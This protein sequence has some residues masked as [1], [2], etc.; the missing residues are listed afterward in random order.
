[1]ALT[2]YRKKRDF[3]KTPEPGGKQ[4]RRG[5][6]SGLQFV[7]Q[8]HAA[9][10]LHYDFRLELDGV[11]KSWAV[12]KGPS[13]DPSVK[14]LA[15]QVEDHPLEYGGFEGVIPEGQYGG[16]TVMLW[17][18]GGWQP[19][20]DPR[21][22]LRRGKLSF[23]LDGEKLHGRWTLIRMRGREDDDRNWLLVK[24]DDEF[25]RS[26]SE[27]DLKE[28][29]SKSVATGRSMEEI[30][31]NAD[32][33]W[34]STTGER[35]NGRAASDT[36]RG[37]GNRRGRSS[38]GN[39][40]SARSANT[41]PAQLS[42]AKKGRPPK[43]FKPQ[44]ATLVSRVPDGED[45]L[46]E[47]KY[48]G[49]RIL[50]FKEGGKVRLVSRNAKDWTGRFQSI[51]DAVAELPVETAVFDG[52]VVVIDAH[53]G[54]DFQALQNLMKSGRTDNL[55]YYVFD[56]PFYSGDDLRQA[57][58]IERKQLLEEVL[59]AR[60]GNRGAVRYSDHVV[61]Q[62]ATVFEHTCR[63]AME[64]IICKRADSG[65]ES[66]RST[67]WLKAKCL[68]RQEFVI[69]GYTDPS[70]SRTHFGAL[71]LGYYDGG[72]LRY[73]GRVGT[74]FNGESLPQ[75]YDELHPRERATPPFVNPPTGRDARGVHWVKPELVAEVEFTAWTE[76]DVLRH[77]S[78]K[79][80]RED[81]PA[82]DVGRE[83][84]VTAKRQAGRGKAGKR[85]AGKRAPLA[86]PTPGGDG[87]SKS[88]SAPA[89]STGRQDGAVEVAGV[90]LSNPD[91]VLY[92][93]AGYTKRQLAEYYASIADWVLPGMAGRPLTIVRCP[94]GRG[95]KCFYQKHLNESVP[96]PIR[97]V[98][99]E[100]KGKRSQYLVI[101]D[102]PGLVTLVQLGVLEVHPWGSRTDNIERPDLMVFD[103]DPGEGVDWPEVVAAAHTV[104][105]RLEGLGLTTF[106]RT[107]GGKG[108]HVV[109]PLVRR[110]EW[111]EVKDFAHAVADDVAAAAPERFI[112]TMSK[113]KRRGKVYVDYLRNGRGAT[114][115]ASYST[116]ARAGATVA[117]P[118]RWDE[119]SNDSAQN[120]WTIETIPRRLVALKEDPWKDFPGTR[121]SITRAMAREV[122][123]K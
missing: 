78:F 74:G 84:V 27:F 98:E 121:Q 99:V 21:K 17:D 46:H 75:I 45:W 91:R 120:T 112:A 14:S 12:P 19:E 76:D 69:G 32:R 15:V 42:G 108:L 90:R 73:C 9:R 114:A 29:E 103:L 43:S 113:A 64:G 53:G 88:S 22:A 7:V 50:A 35:S 30:A 62:G 68:K 92:P 122:T 20:D 97:G 3:R 61:G 52:E 80:L 59:E 60:D 41:D 71:L 106:L 63:Y 117:T 5:S 55:V 48:D 56:L 82:K 39:G 107:T 57:P 10:R 24:G 79:G 123:V 47:L 40:S 102:L 109:V 23:E 85:A 54:T 11:L 104:R 6:T 118:I 8:K 83:K 31:A 16:G 58:L 100:E 94:Q 66:R 65:Y 67:T 36:R 13:L 26:E 77:S 44:L 86:I 18:R 1:M 93:E 49:Y 51:A 87:M 119:L 25:A 95:A 116:R 101:D 111:D 2:E 89:R 33:V 70:G 110:H 38:G 34:D 4:S 81:K 28:A 115:I 96:A 72:E 105:E 37:K